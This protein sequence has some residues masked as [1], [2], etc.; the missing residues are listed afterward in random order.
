MS[1]TM[2]SAWLARL[3][4]LGGALGLDEQ[5]LIHAEAVDVVSWRGDVA[6]DL[7]RR[8]TQKDLDRWQTAFG[9]ALSIDVELAA[10][11]DGSEARAWE[12]SDG[13]AALHLLVEYAQNYVGEVNLGWTL[14]KGILLD[15]QLAG[16]DGKH[17]RTA[18]ARLFFFVRRLRETLHQS[19][20]RT[21]E[22]GLLGVEDSDA[23][24]AD[25]SLLVLVADVPG[26]LDGS[27]VTVAGH[28]H[29]DQAAAVL[30]RKDPFDR[31]ASDREIRR[32][33][34][35]WSE[36]P[37]LLTPAFVDL[38]DGEAAGDLALVHAELMAIRHR[39]AAA[40]LASRSEK[41]NATLRSTFEGQRS[42]TLTLG[43]ESEAP[44]LF[45]LYQWAYG[46][47]Q[48]AR[49]KLMI[50]R[51]VVASQ[52]P[53]GTED[54]GILVKN[55]E[56]VLKECVIQLRIL[57][58]R[59][60]V[61]SFEWRR[62]FD[63][64]V[65]GY[66]DEVGASVRALARE[67]VDNVYKTAGLLLG[68]GIAYLLKPS[69][70]RLVLGLGVG[71][72]L[73][74]VL[75]V[76]CF[77]LESV[78]QDFESKKRAFEREKGDIVATGLI[79]EDFKTRFEAVEERNTDFTTKF[80]RA[81]SVYLI[82]VLAALTGLLAVSV[83][84]RTETVE[85]VRARALT[86]QVERFEDIGHLEVR[87]A[88]GGQTRPEL[89]TAADSGL[90]LVPDLTAI[91]AGGRLLIVEYVPCAAIGKADELERLSRAARLAGERRAQLQ[92]L[93]AAACGAQPGPTAVRAWLEG[94]GLGPFET[95]TF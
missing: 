86:R 28:D 12:A 49:T 42:V 45:G 3:R 35:A 17:G 76:R 7:L 84:P 16:N 53:V 54:F 46:E 75:F 33:N 26:W 38:D 6:L 68:V 78:R 64:L 9:G 10:E 19:D 43:A 82:I 29:W 67:V 69:E 55:A 63:T 47:P 27:F 22:E 30:G 91:D 59:N 18:I 50:V 44:K 74:Y 21:F 25:R 88:V 72:N 85:A 1:A 87:A 56:G 61:E 36:P 83:I 8:I 11:E 24:P 14:D 70:G 71:L 95:W 31:L 80:D 89:L 15:Q 52:L 13:E 60:V 66:L 51:R 32:L 20:F 92:L 23:G 94:A 41:Q 79:A 77:Y 40:Y 93:T 90:H 65:R 4:E 48:V 58:D 34:C 5:G 37:R 62:K 2:E 81:S 73:A 57:V 39:L